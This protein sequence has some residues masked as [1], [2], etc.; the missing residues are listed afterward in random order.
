MPCSVATLT[1]SSKRTCSQKR[2]RNSELETQNSELDRAG[3]LMATTELNEKPRVIVVRN[4]RRNEIVAV[5]LLA[6]GLLLSLCLVSAAFFPN[7]PSWNSAGQTEIRNWAGAI[8]ANVAAALFQ[9]IGIAAFLLPPLLFAA[10]WRRFRA[11]KIQA[12]FYPL[13]GLITLVL[14]ASALLSISQ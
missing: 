2:Q 5:L 6:L 14:S 3:V 7:D 11:R 12:P 10:A 13:L 8:G 1:I 4:S 9:T